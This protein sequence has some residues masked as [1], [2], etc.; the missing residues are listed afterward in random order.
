MFLGVSEKNQVCFGLRPLQTPPCGDVEWP[1]RQ[2]SVE[3]AGTCCEQF[4]IYFRYDSYMS[5]SDTPIH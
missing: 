4:P 3:F 2:Q 1:E 5:R